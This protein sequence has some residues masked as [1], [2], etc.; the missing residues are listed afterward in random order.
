[1]TNYGLNYRWATIT[2][3]GPGQGATARAVRAPYG[4][5]GKDPINGMFS[6]TLMFYTNISRDTNQGFAVNNDFR[7]LG[8]IKNPR[9]F[10]ELALVKSALAS[11]CY[12]VTGTINTS[13]FTP[14]MDLFLGTLSG[15]K[16]RIVAVTS[17]AVLIQSLDNAVP[18]VGSV[19]LNSDSETFT[20]SGVTAPTV[21]K[22]SGDMLFIDNKQAFT[23]TT[24][25]T[26]TLRT[27]IKF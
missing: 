23:P 26:V 2:I 4:G 7:Q 10:G 9:K 15:R 17:T 6:R 19:F 1:V 13:N 21:D 27:V 12:V 20:A 3:G 16:F 11:A 18:V 5:H 14:D 8:I 24:D 22:Y 25:Q